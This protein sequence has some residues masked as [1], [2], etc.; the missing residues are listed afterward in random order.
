M[1][2]RLETSSSS[3]DENTLYQL[4]TIKGNDTDY[5]IESD[6]DYAMD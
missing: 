5:D 2:S 6:Q 4:N 3:S 1:T